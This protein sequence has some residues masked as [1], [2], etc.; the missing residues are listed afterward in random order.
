MIEIKHID[1]SRIEGEQF[2]FEEGTKNSIFIEDNSLWITAEPEL[3]KLFETEINNYYAT[4]TFDITK[5]FIQE[6]KAL[7]MVMENTYEEKNND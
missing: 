5:Q 2:S 1:Y 3:D 4:I 6:L 7:V